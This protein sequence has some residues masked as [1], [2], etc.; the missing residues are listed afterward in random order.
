MLRKTAMGIAAAAAAVMLASPVS[1]G[2]YDRDDD[3]G[4]R[5]DGRG[6]YDDRGDRGDYGGYKGSAPYYR[7]PG[8]GYSSVTVY[9]AAPVVV[10]AP[11]Y[12]AYPAYSYGYAN[13][14]CK[15]WKWRKWRKRRCW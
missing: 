3:R 12:Y 8:Y 1:A 7:A 14:G 15:R 6:Y 5:D 13:C 9:Q 10:P 11:A 4:Y 2:G